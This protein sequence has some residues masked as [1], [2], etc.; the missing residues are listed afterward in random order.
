MMFTGMPFKSNHDLIQPPNTSHAFMLIYTFKVSHESD[1]SKQRGL[2]ENAEVT[3]GYNF[4]N[5]I[6]LG[7]V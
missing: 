6:C 3:A 2:R 4:K 1:A 5:R 7:E